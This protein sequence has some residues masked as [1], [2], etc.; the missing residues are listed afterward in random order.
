[1]IAGL[2][3]KMDLYQKMAYGSL[4]NNVYDESIIFH[5]LDNGKVVVQEWIKPFLK[6][7]S[8]GSF[9]L[10]YVN[11]ENYDFSGTKG[12]NLFSE[13]IKDNTLANTVLSG[14]TF[15]CYKENNINPID[16]SLVNITGA[17]FTGSCGA[18]VSLE[19]VDTLPD[20]CNLTDALIVIK[21]SEDIAKFNLDRFKNNLFI[22]Q[23]S[24]VHG[25]IVDFNITDYCKYT[26]LIN[27]YEIAA[28]HDA[29]KID[30]IDSED[31]RAETNK[32]VA[33]LI[34]SE[35]SNSIDYNFLY[36]IFKAA[37]MFNDYQNGEE[38][39]LYSLFEKIKQTDEYKKMSNSNVIDELVNI[40]NYLFKPYKNSIKIED[41]ILNI[42]TDNGLFTIDL[43]S[44]CDYLNHSYSA[45]QI[46]NEVFDSFYKFVFKQE[47][48][49]N[50]KNEQSKN[51]I[52]VLFSFSDCYYFGEFVNSYIE[53]AIFNALE[54]NNYGYQTD[55]KRLK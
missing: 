42:Y 33:Y 47:E 49:G 37:I 7:I 9:S 44:M 32:A 29:L 3:E 30:C 24:I 17:D 22:K 35:L 14:V 5:K 51:I 54:A 6:Q 41:N 20:N 4:C 45:R 18:I 53:K 23:N 28:I 8:F 15:H 13:E 40:C 25:K 39:V 26:G 38:N 19:N 1:M 46:L 50:D 16:A 43:L 21:S 52:D 2:K 31:T 48:S 11:I 12:F 55:I 10:A 36:N 27:K 34:S